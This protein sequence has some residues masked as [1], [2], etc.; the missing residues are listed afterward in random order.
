VEDEEAQKQPELV[1]ACST[2]GLV[3]TV[4]C[5]IIFLTLYL[6]SLE[7]EIATTISVPWESHFWWKTRCERIV[8]SIVVVAAVR[9]FSRSAEME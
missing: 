7:G 8:I 6:L 5:W 9:L 1:E 3:V 2:K 4:N